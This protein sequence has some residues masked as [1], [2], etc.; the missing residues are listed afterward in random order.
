M[1]ERNDEDRDP[2]ACAEPGCPMLGTVDRGS[3]GRFLCSAHAWAEPARWRG[4]TEALNRQ[5]RLRQFIADLRRQDS[6][7]PAVLLSAARQVWGDGSP[8][9]PA[10]WETLEAYRERMHR[11]LVARVEEAVS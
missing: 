8:L 11:E 10:S 5:Q 6:V 2:L 9:L 3:S 1:R 4:I 7:A